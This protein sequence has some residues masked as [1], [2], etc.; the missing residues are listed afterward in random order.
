[1]SELNGWIRAAMVDDGTTQLP[2]RDFGVPMRPRTGPLA[3]H[4][5][6]VYR[7]GRDPDVQEALAR[8]HDAYIDCLSLAGIRTPASRL[9]LLEEAGTQRP[10]LV[11]AAVSD[12]MM[13]P[14]LIQKAGSNAAIGLLDLVAT[15]VSEFWRRVAQRPERIGFHTPLDHFAMDE[16]GPLFLETFPPLISYSRDEMGQLIQRFCDS[17]L[18]RGVGKVLPG[19]IRDIQDRW[20]TPGGSIITLIDG[21]L[22]LRPQDGDAIFEWAEHFAQARLDGAGRDAVH[23]HLSRAAHRKGQVARRWPGFGGRDRPHA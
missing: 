1:M 9:H 18:I 5:L 22:R 6:T 7:G 16:D 21:A 15:E 14:G 12:D 2:A 11:Q 20:Y 17:A 13:L 10:V 3:G 8:R 23:A 19:R 4:I